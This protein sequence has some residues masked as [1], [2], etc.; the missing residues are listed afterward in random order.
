[1]STGRGAASSPV[2]EP[3]QAHVMRPDTNPATHLRLTAPPDIVT[4][5]P[6]LLGFYPAES[7]VL[8]SIG[9]ADGPYVRFT[10]R[11]DL[12]P[13]GASA[14]VARDLVGIDALRESNEILVVV[15]GGGGPPGR[16]GRP[17]RAELVTAVAAQCERAGIP[18]RA[19][20]W[21]A[22]IAKGAR[23]S[24]YGGC[25][26]AGSLPD[27]ACAPITAE[28]VADGK[29]IYADRAEV[30]RLVMPGHEPTLARRS[31]LIELYLD[32]MER[33]GRELPF[34]GAEGLAL[35]T[36]WVDAAATELPPL[37]DEDVLS[38]G[39]ALSDPLVRDVCLGLT[40]GSSAEPARRLWAA[41]VKELPD[42]EVAEPAVLLA[43]SAVMRGD[44]AVATVALERAQLAWPGHHLSAMF[45]D[46]LSSGASP[47]MLRATFA[48]GIADAEKALLNGGAG[49]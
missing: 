38:L 28:M 20:V 41:L 44:S 1:M 29:V 46:A 3:A 19:S 45:L 7:L 34:G 15:V 37:T 13:P 26:C 6:A 23:W 36:R 21:V 14:E 17:P 33:E 43:F 31:E 25:H 5:I 30:E 24:C 2:V 47:A 22:E 35:V 48:E 16:R 4:A 18:L 11:I 10:L 27:P 32:K 39:L 42:P 12:P 49:A 8:V 9:M 40:F